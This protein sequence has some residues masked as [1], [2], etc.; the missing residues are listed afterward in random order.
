[1]GESVSRRSSVSFGEAVGWLT[2]VALAT[3][4]V[5]VALGNLRWEVSG[6]LN[7]V[8]ASAR[9]RQALV[10]ALTASRDQPVGSPT[11][12]SNASRIRGAIP[13]WV[14][15]LARTRV[16]LPDGLLDKGTETRFR[17]ESAVDG[18]QHEIAI[19]TKD[20][21]T[22][23]RLHGELVERVRLTTT[24]VSQSGIDFEWR[25]GAYLAT[26]RRVL[27]NE[28]R[29]GI[30]EDRLSLSAA[31]FS[32]DIV[33]LEELL[34][35]RREWSGE[36]I[37]DLSWNLKQGADGLPAP[38]RTEEL[39]RSLYRMRSLSTFLAGGF[40]ALPPRAELVW[41]LFESTRQEP[42]FG[43]SV[44]AAGA[45]SAKLSSSPVS[46][47]P[48]VSTKGMELCCAMSIGVF[49]L[50]WTL[51]RRRRDP[52]VRD[53]EDLR[54]ALESAGG[55]L[56]GKPV[57]LACDAGT[58]MR[59]IVEGPEAAAEARPGG[60]RVGRV[61]CV[62][63]ST[64]PSAEFIAAR[65]ARSIASVG[66]TAVAVV[67]SVGRQDRN[68]PLIWTDI[69]D[70]RQRV[71]NLVSP[72][73]IPG[74]WHFPTGVGGCSPCYVAV[75]EADPV[76]RRTLEILQGRF[77][78]VVVAVAP[79]VPGID[80]PNCPWAHRCLFAIQ[81][82]SIRRSALYRWLASTT[83]EMPIGFVLADGSSSVAESAESQDW[84]E[85]LSGSPALAPVGEGT[86]AG[87]T[88]LRIL[89][90]GSSISGDQA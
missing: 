42:S 30:V 5:V 29:A 62:Y 63:G 15:S 89:S 11:A 19:E 37:D 33:G 76:L 3:L 60:S 83:R 26:V 78:W 45:S 68:S 47:R 80:L 72:S 57:A 28:N 38:S 34:G 35:R 46:F 53:R 70:G 10:D 41:F 40:T 79:V 50:A 51:V 67:E 21:S 84:V 16:P 55:R 54:E 17:V 59:S 85:T 61:V 12:N 43:G 36:L 13:A 88:V 73:D 48:V 58:V 25:P 14:S 6:N 1:V 32:D 71:E 87:E 56:A 82:G 69:A 52:V 64:L 4:G 75:S 8:G 66:R 81:P 24:R 31:R 18:S 22:A 49:G 77:D 9:E 90:G 74:L 20:P 39:I 7:F 44:S 65:V 2:C 86:G 27:E 23:L